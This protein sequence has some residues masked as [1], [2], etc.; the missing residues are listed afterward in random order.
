GLLYD[1]T[2]TLA[3][4][5]LEIYISKATTVLDQIA[6]TFYVKDTREAGFQKLSD[7]ERIAAL[8]RALLDAAQLEEVGD[9]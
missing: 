2:R 9:G 4:H 1:L 8:Q 7:P 5:D 3:E 6:D